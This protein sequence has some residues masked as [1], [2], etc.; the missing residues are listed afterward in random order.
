M[1]TSPGVAAR[2]LPSS[3]RPL[4]LVT[5]GITSHGNSSHAKQEISALNVKQRL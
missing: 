4:Q 2:V 1:P 3:L 5:R